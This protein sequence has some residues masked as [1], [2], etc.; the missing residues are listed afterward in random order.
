[1]PTYQC[2]VRDYR[3]EAFMKTM[4][5]ENAEEV[6]VRLREMGYMVVTPVTLKKEGSRL[7]EAASADI[8]FIDE[9]N[10]RLAFLQTVKLEDLT[11]FA[12]QFATMI[13]AGVA[14]VRALT[15]LS[16]QTPNVKLRNIVEEIKLKVE[17]GNS[18]SEALA[19][20]PDVFD[21][22]F[23]G[24]I[25]AGEAGG[26]LDEVLLRIAGFMESAA[27]LRGQVKSAMTYPVVV[28]IM[29]IGIFVAMLMFIMPIFANMFSQMNAKLPAYTQFLIDLSNTMKGP[30]GLVVFATIAGVVVAF[31]QFAAT[32]HGKHFLDRYMLQLPIVG[33]LTQKVAVARF[34]RTLGTL[35]RSGVPLL[36][37]L[38][39]V[40]DSAGNMVVS[41]A[42][43]D[44]RQAVREG[45]GISKP[46]EKAD[47][48]PPM[49]T[50]M[51][52]VGEETGS[53]DSMLEK[54]ADFYD[55][56]VEATIKSLTSLLEPLMMVFIGLLVGSIVVGMYLPIFSI[57]NTVG[58]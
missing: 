57:I 55:T 42:V 38:E 37:A 9:I 8:P 40:R 39:I 29:A 56:E 48:F 5:G 33:P 32:D 2:K 11:I 1:M 47:I 25:R 28:S 20:Y 58:K 54:I 10:K 21:N 50:Q 23:V 16:E 12:R 43:E 52:S 7:G 14:M 27:K 35:L 53:I 36:N 22:L 18:L 34:T 30:M 13:N 51:V 44:I 24:M 6:R 26:V 49:V 31:R 45:E 17:Q 41:G 46:L 3:G 15:I 19:R 4:Q